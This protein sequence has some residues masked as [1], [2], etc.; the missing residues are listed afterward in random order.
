M[1]LLKIGAL[2]AVGILVWVAYQN[3]YRFVRSSP[4]GTTRVKMQRNHSAQK[5]FLREIGKSEGMK[6][7]AFAYAISGIDPNHQSVYNK[8]LSLD[9]TTTG[10]VRSAFRK[11]FYEQR[12]NFQLDNAR[13]HTAHY[14]QMCDA[15]AADVRFLQIYLR[16]K[17]FFA[18]M[19][20][21]LTSGAD[22]YAYR[23]PD[24][25]PSE[26]TL[27]HLWSGYLERP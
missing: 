19:L 3:R 9:A 22:H 15:M 7:V 20:N 24:I 10:H 17:E 21:N 18:M 27:Q 13:D 12:L 26:E 11:N 5:T 4:R 6:L 8:A 23:N 1:S 14:Q 25:M 16:N 2:V